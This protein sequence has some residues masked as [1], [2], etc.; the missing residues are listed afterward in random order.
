ML[1]RSTALINRVA[2]RA[3]AVRIAFDAADAEDALRL[4]FPS[5]ELVPFRAELPGS[6]AAYDVVIVEADP[7]R[8]QP[9]PAALGAWA[10]F[11]QRL[12][13]EGTL[14]VT[15]VAPDDEL[16]LLAAEAARSLGIDRAGAPTIAPAEAFSRLIGPLASTLEMGHARVTT[17]LRPG[18]ESLFVESERGPV[19]ATL[20]A[21]GGAESEAGRAFLAEVARLRS[22]RPTAAQPLR[23]GSSLCTASHIWALATRPSLMDIYSE[24]GSYHDGQLSKG[25]KS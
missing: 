6:E 20:A 19:G 22:S 9:A 16:V 7:A 13:P 21:I 5:A 23:D 17:R 3:G 8:H 24:Y 4:R 12:R 11:L 18:T 2:P 10:D 25:W 1:P 14:A 15:H